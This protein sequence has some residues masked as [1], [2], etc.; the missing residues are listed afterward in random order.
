EGIR[1]Y[2]DEY[3]QRV[4]ELRR[5][6]PQQIRLFDT[7]EALNTPAGLQEL[8][9]FAGIAPARQIASV[10]THVNDPPERPKRRWA[11]RS[12][13]NPMDPKRCAILIPFATS[14]IP[15]CERA[16]EELERR[17]YDVRRVGGYAAIDQ[18]RN[19]MATDALLDGYEETMWIDAD[20]D[21]HPDS[22]DRLRSHGL[23]IAGGIYPQK[24][25]RA[26][27]SHIMPGM[28]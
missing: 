17:G 13:G 10:G 2:W 1:R 22:V 28:P 20:V 26:L 4:E 6:Y 16:L 3:Y 19:Q 12:G 18:G 24:G 14:I 11:R 8:L 7:Y 25:K 9:A 5:R 27:A 15:P 21:F 23:P